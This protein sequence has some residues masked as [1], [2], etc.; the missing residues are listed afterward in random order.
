MVIPSIIFYFFVC[1]W[2]LCLCV[3]MLGCTNVS[4]SAVQ[5][6]HDSEYQ[7]RILPKVLYFPGGSDVA[8]ATE[9]VALEQPDGS[10]QLFGYKWFSSATDSDMSLTLANILREDQPEPVRKW[11]EQLS[12]FSVNNYYSCCLCISMSVHSFYSLGRSV[13]TLSCSDKASVVFGCIP[14]LFCDDGCVT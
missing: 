11:M 10:H 7:Y 3:S 8:G 1:L 13:K 12:N 4:D 9:T 14:K 2:A 6:R 5:Y